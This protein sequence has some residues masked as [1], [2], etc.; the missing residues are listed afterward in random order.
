[1]GTF[2]LAQNPTPTGPSWRLLA[3]I[4]LAVA[5]LWLYSKIDKWR[6]K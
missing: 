1:M 6:N 3:L 5:A 4:V 2:W